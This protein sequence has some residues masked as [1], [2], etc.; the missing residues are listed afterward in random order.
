VQARVSHR[1]EQSMTTALPPDVYAAI[2]DRPALISAPFVHA[3]GMNGDVEKN[4]QEIYDIPLLTDGSAAHTKDAPAWTNMRSEGPADPYMFCLQ[5]L[6]LGVE[7]TSLGGIMIDVDPA[8]TPKKYAAVAMAAAK[9]AMGFA[10]PG[11]IKML[12]KNL[13]PSQHVDLAFA[14]HVEAAV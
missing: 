14:H 10:K 11:D 9:R 8:A 12:E 5:L 1:N 6:G 2:G 3:N 4:V 13:H 7:D